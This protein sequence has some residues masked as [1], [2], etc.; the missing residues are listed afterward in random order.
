LV[1]LSL[2]LLWCCRSALAL[3]LW[4]SGRRSLG[5]SSRRCWT[6][7]HSSLARGCSSSARSQE[8]PGHSRCRSLFGSRTPNYHR[9]SAGHSYSF[10]CSC[11]TSLSCPRSIL[12]T[13]QNRAN[14]RLAYQPHSCIDS[15]GTPGS[16]IRSSGPDR[17][18]SNRQWSTA[19]DTWSWCRDCWDSTEPARMLRRERSRP[20]PRMQKSKRS[21]FGTRVSS[22]AL[23]ENSNASSRCDCLGNLHKICGPN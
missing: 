19:S 14:N 3:W 11:H 4:E 23:D 2:V 6:S 16:H 7:R 15:R 9:K 21:S 12:R 20:W 18:R 13:I 8:R 1:R 5:E 17:N 22:S 10:D